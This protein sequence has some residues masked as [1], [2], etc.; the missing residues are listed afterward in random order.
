MPEFLEK[1]EELQAIIRKLHLQ[2]N[3]YKVEVFK[4]EFEVKKLNDE[5]NG[6]K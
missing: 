5:S 4:R 6:T 3:Q 2:N 1:I